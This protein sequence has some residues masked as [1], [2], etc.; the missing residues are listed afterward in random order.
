MVHEPK[1]AES[2][3]VETWRFMMKV[4][5]Y[6]HNTTDYEAE[7]RFLKHLKEILYSH[8]PLCYQLIGDLVGRCSCYQTH[9]KNQ[10]L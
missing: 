9:E 1:I 2:V 8:K 10:K 5:P 3:K 7:N 4:E 6:D